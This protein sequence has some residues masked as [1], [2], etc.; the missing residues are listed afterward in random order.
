MDATVELLLDIQ[1]KDVRISN[2]KR[3]IANVPAEKKAVADEIT[4]AETKLEQARQ[5]VLE[6]EKLIKTVEVDIQ[7]ANNKK[8]DL[9]RKSF[10]VKKNEEYKAI[11]SEIATT[12]E[13]ISDLETDELEAMEKLDLAKAARIE[14]KKQFEA[15]K[16]RL[17]GSIDDL[18]LR[19]QNAQ[20]QVDKLTAERN[21]VAANVD[22]E[23]LR[24]YER[25]TARPA[26]DGSFR[27]ALAPIRENLCGGCMLSLTPQARTSVR[28]GKVVPC[29]NCGC[30]MYDSGE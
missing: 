13:R 5:Q 18:D 10:E 2:L 1:D 14:A 8:I 24:F 7:T 15:T 9:T 11:L 25:L 4:A 29:Q 20:A 22:E 26:A 27:K 3:Q 19:Q 30:L 6:V 17:E 28:A 16:T 21:A 23:N 12:E